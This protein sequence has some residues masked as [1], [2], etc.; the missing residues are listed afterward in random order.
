M[1]K[2]N[3]A[4][5][6]V[7]LL[8]VVLIIGI[9]AA[10]ALPQYKKATIKSRFVQSKIMTKALA[11]AEE[12]FFLA[13][14]KYATSFDKLDISMPSDYIKR[15][16]AQT[17]DT[18]FF[19]WGSCWIADDQWGSRV[20]C[21]NTDGINLY[22]Y[23]QNSPIDA[24]LKQCRAYNTDLTSIQNQICKEESGKNATYINNN[25]NYAD[26]YYAN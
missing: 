8:V 15:S 7:E 9:L 11:Q 17:S 2:C 6:L 14:G 26:Y 24:N 12:V 10:I 3:K 25:E 20:A 5:T 22:I 23:L 13:N 18:L 16:S 1:K 19:S 21:N 4:F